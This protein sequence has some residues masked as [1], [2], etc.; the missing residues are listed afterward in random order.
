M[1]LFNEYGNIQDE[2]TKNVRDL[3]DDT[4]KKELNRLI[5]EGASI[6][7]IKAIAREFTVAVDLACSDVI[8][9]QQHKMGAKNLRHRLKPNTTPDA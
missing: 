5:K 2:Q 3:I 1:S 4:C 7:D 6:I 8:I 9:Y